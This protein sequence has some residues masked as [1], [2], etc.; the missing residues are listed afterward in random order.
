MRIIG[1]EFKRR[2]LHTPPDERTTRPMPDL[3]RESLFNILRGHS[4]GATVVDA[5][6]GTGAVGLEAV[7]RGAA[8]CV[9]IERDRRIATIVQ[10]NIDELGVADR[11]ELIVGDA[12]GPGALARCP[13]SID[14]LFFD[15]PYPLV[16]DAGTWPRVRDQFGRFIA[17]LS[18]QGFAVLRTP[19][20]AV[21]HAPDEPEV[22]PPGARREVIEGAE[23]IV[24]EADTV[25]GID[26]EALEAF[27]QAARE[28][29]RVARERARPV[30][31]DLAVPGAQGP[32]T[33][34]Y[35]TTALHLYMRQ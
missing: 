5:F 35:G 15:P 20:P 17:R 8:R 25:D 32:E 6:A 3:V 28:A 29:E 7:S 13:A 9:L 27:E 4:E 19:W 1:G 18:P 31:I 2:K 16:T 14:L 22:L 24:L 23:T 26:D 10:A 21:H 30:D 11:C 12:L 33:H 34:H